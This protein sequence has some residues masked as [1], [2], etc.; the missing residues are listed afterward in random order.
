[1]LRHAE[2]EQQMFCRFLVSTNKKKE[3]RTTNCGCALSIT[4]LV[5]VYSFVANECRATTTTQ[6]QAGV[7]IFSILLL[8]VNNHAFCFRLVTSSGS[9]SRKQRRRRRRRRRRNEKKMGLDGGTIVNSRS[10]LRA[11]AAQRDTR[12]NDDGGARSDNELAQL[13]HQR[14]WHHCALS[15][16]PLSC[17]PIV[18]DMKGNLM[19]KTSALELVLAKRTGT[20]PETPAIASALLATGA[21]QKFDHI[22]SMKHDVVELKL[23]AAAAASTT[24]STTAAPAQVATNEAQISRFFACSVLKTLPPATVAAAPFFVRWKC[25]HILSQAALRDALE[26]DK[27]TAAAAA[28]T[29]TTTSGSTP[30]A[31]I[32]LHHCPVADCDKPSGASPVVVLVPP[33][34]HVAGERRQRE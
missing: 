11:A 20:I 27:A 8:V 4:R 13:E 25:G 14:R 23:A 31:G 19:L 3:R 21:Q 6:K 2:D 18:A 32:V 1:M 34:E 24:T 22:K 15:G 7:N 28:A 33:H 17:P 12:S 5:D 29:T 30:H 16:Q 10:T 26:A 9:N